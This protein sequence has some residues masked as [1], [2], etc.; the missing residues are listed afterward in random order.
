MDRR[1]LAYAYHKQGY[2]CAQSVAGAFGDRTG[3]PM[4]RTA[5]AMGAF[6]RGVGGEA[7][8]CG[9]LS[10]AVLV[11]SLLFPYDGSDPEK[12]Q[13]LYGLAQELRER[14]LA[15][16]GHTRCGDLL[17]AQPQLGPTARR[18]GAE[19]PCDGLI[20]TAVELLEQLLS[21][22]EGERRGLWI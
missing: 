14:F 12:K 11:L 17:S 22:L 15:S 4:D 6:G 18:L 10:G 7:E 20:I 19:T 13:A 16:F 1:A 21:E 8:L 9:A 3:W 2:N 5:A